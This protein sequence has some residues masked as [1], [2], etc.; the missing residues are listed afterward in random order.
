MTTGRQHVQEAQERKQKARKATVRPGL[1][2]FL[3]ML[4]LWALQGAAYSQSFQANPA[5]QSPRGPIAVRDMRPYN[6]LFL[7]FLPE[8]GDVLPRKAERFGLQFDV[9]NNLL[10]PA[11][12]DGPV[13]IE[14][15]EYQRLSLSWRHGMGK[16]TEIALYVPLLW[17]NGGFLDSILSSYHSLVGYNGAQDDNPAGRDAY[18][19]YQSRLVL[20]DVNGN[21]LI[22]QGNAFGLGETLLTLKRSLVRPTPRSAVALRLGVKL[23]TGNPTLLLG[24]GSPDLGISLD[25]RYS[26]GREIILYAN[27]AG[28]VMGKANKLPE[29]RSGMVQTLV[30]LEYRPNNRDSF[31]LQFDSN[32][33]AVRTGNGIADRLQ[34]TG[35]VG[36]KRVLDRH[37]VLAVSFSENGDVPNY[38]APTIASI[39]PDFTVS[40]GLEWHR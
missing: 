11:L 6:L 37:Y 15:N 35:T 2:A 38:A 22:D 4:S 26:V 21:V 39:G 10:R 34:T 20:A 13:V 30:G 9:A 16:E 33:L 32:S 17:R 28:V 36:Y 19:K 3:T 27:L 12:D 5:Y 7:Q 24:S 1:K 23:P 14:D 8:S 29:A 18:P 31:I 25:A 40:L